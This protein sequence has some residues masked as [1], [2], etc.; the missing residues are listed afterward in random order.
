MSAKLREFACFSFSS[1]PNARRMYKPC[2][3]CSSI[4]TKSGF[5]QLT[6]IHCTTIWQNY[7]FYKKND[8]PNGIKN[9][10]AR[11]QI[12]SR[13]TPQSCSLPAKMPFQSKVGPQYHSPLSLVLLLIYILLIFTFFTFSS[14]CIFY[15]VFCFRT[16]HFPLFWLAVIAF[17][18]SFR[19]FLWFWIGKEPEE[20]WTASYYRRVSFFAL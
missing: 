12:S 18:L 10:S 8:P 5:E 15:S 4:S 11:S 9:Y 19:S 6:Y 2:H 1:M 16:W 7:S 14:P 13:Q 20:V 3:D 17:A